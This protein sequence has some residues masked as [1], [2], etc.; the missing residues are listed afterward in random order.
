MIN[1]ELS[2]LS[3]C[4][5]YNLDHWIREAVYYSFHR[6]VRPHHPSWYVTQLPQY[7]KHVV[8][9]EHDI[10]REPSSGRLMWTLRILISLSVN[11]NW[12][13][14]LEVVEA[15]FRMPFVRSSWL[16][17][18]VSYFRDW[19]SAKT[20]QGNPAWYG[21]LI[22]SDVRWEGSWGAHLCPLSYMFQRLAP[23][24][25]TAHRAE[26]IPCIRWKNGSSIYVKSVWITCVHSTPSTPERKAYIFNKL[27][28][29]TVV[30][31]KWR[32]S[33]ELFKSANDIE[34][35]FSI[36]NHGIKE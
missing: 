33:R 2:S 3:Q 27:S 4:C 1:H 18:N 23:Y 21:G 28:I 26:L 35:G 9:Q 10:L 16:V 6:R 17:P 5:R 36:Y 15:Y 20:T 12:Y 22:I 30:T 25:S 7:R 31:V 24:P 13:S 32:S 8:P 11:V 29:R 14:K 19:D 34:N